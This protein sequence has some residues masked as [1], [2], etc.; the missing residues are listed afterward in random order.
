MTA[1]MI[2]MDAAAGVLQAI[3]AP[4]ANRTVTEYRLHDKPAGLRK[5]G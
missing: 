4:H 3:P 5:A 1:A 2:L